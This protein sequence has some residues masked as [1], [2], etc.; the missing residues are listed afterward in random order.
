ML[1]RSSQT[2]LYTYDFVGWS[3][4]IV[5][6][7][8]DVTYSANFTQTNRLYKVEWKNEYGI[9]LE[10]DYVLFHE[11]PTFN[12]LSP[13]KTSTSQYDYQF[14]GWSPQIDQITENTTYYATFEGHIRSYNITF[15][16]DGNQITNSYQYGQVPETNE[17]EKA[18]D[19]VYTYDFSHWIPTV[20]PVSGNA[21]YVAV[22]SQSLKQYEITFNTFGGSEVVNQTVAYGSRLV[23]PQ[24]PTKDGL[25]FGGW[26]K[27]LS[28]SQ[29]WNFAIDKVDD[30]TQVLYAKWL[31]I[32]DYQVVQNGIIITQYN[33]YNAAD[34]IIPEMI[35]T[36][37]V[38]GLS[39]YSFANH[40]EIIT[41]QFETPENIEYI[42]LGAFSG[43]NSISEIQLP[44]IG[45]SLTSIGSEA[46]FGYIFGTEY[47]PL[48]L[49]VQQFHS[50]E[51]YTYYYVP[52]SLKKITV[53]LDNDIQYGAF[54]NL[55]N[56]QTLVLNEGIEYIG[57]KAF[58]NMNSMT[59][60][61]I[62]TSASTI[63]EQA[64]FGLNFLET[65]SI[66]LVD[67]NIGT[68]FGTEMYSNSYVANGFYIPK[69]L[70][71]ITLLETQNITSSAFK[72]Y[73][74]VEK[75][76]IPNSVLSIA[77][78][79]LNGMRSLKSVTL[80]FTGTSRTAT[81]AS[82]YFGQIFGA[83]SYTNS[84]SANNY[85]IPISL[86]EVIITDTTRLGEFAFYNVSLVEELLLP[87]MLTT[88]ETYALA[89]M[90]SI[91]TIE[92]PEGLTT[93]GS[94]AF[95]NM[96]N[97]ESLV[98]PNT[99]VSIGLNAFDFMSKL[100]SLTIP[101]VGQSRSATSAAAYFGSVFGTTSYTGS[102][103]AN[104][105]YL[106]SSLIEVNITDTTSIGA[107][108]FLNTTAITN[109]T[110]PETLLSIGNNAFQQSGITSII[111]NQGLLT[112]GNYA[113]TGTKL[114]SITIPNTVTSLGGHAISNIPTLT[115][116]VFEDNS[117]LSLINEYTFNNTRA[118]TSIELP[119]SITTIQGYAFYQSGLTHIEIPN[120][121]TSIGTYAFYD[122]Y[123]STV[124]FEED[125]TLTSIG[126]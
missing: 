86:K 102:Y 92:L 99:V 15:I 112:I 5:P 23:E 22:F 27:D 29:K 87:E 121:I 2:D 39:D 12:G 126:S 16:V 26:Y 61:E 82:G 35:D 31:N 123:L 85:Y 122:N 36:Y 3:P 48:S 115:S 20:A 119:D 54:S 68:K 73:S 6:V 80:P 98:I 55:Y 59:S 45:N 110:L 38:R 72:S 106:P 4:L 32:Y 56:T 108:A 70:K 49:R 79:A 114:T 118:L 63:N 83:D 107:N 58:M 116:V 53:A 30:M 76:I 105:Y 124:T 25:I 113:F 10:T 41:M 7:T 84:Y 89:G 97:I 75:L 19:L 46:L 111:L 90:T 74:S 14:S 17:P 88:I 77:S 47:F 1:F 81:G 65:I 120:T 28:G 78:G 64:L 71:E 9:I 66:P 21:T 40:K 44:F 91:T 104:G 34:V 8:E 94:N 57:R 43:N 109:I 62:P 67:G 37:I 51:D 100:K 60:L 18:S 69:G 42:G 93:I 125:S 50:N 103:N 117:S 52:Y 96:N 95:R 24:E 101:F 33:L 11:I 13:T